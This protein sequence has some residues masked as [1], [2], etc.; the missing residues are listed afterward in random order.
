MNTTFN[1]KADFDRASAEDRA[2]FMQALAASLWRIDADAENKRWLVI[3]DN[4]AIERFGLT[5]AD[6]P[7]AVPPVAPEWVEDSVAGVAAA[8]RSRADAVSRI[9]VTTA[10]GR[11]F[12]GDELSQSRM[13]RAVLAMERAGVAETEWVLADNTVA[14]V[15]ADELAEA[16]ALAGAEQSRLWVLPYASA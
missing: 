4:S 8:K 2:V 7:G 9:Q 15:S 3:E 11:V 6:F 1:C 13:A 5:R 14:S 16:L 12:D 10:S